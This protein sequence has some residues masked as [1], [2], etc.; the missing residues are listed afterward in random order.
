MQAKQVAMAVDSSIWALGMIC[1]H[2]V[3]GRVLG[4][5]APAKLESSRLAKQLGNPCHLLA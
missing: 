1:E 5:K 3:D 4:E 2:Q